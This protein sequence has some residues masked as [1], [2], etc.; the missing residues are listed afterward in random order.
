[1]LC[2]HLHAQLCAVLYLR[3]QGPGAG[4]SV[5]TVACCHQ[6]FITRVCIWQV[7]ASIQLSGVSN[8]EQLIPDYTLSL[9][10]RERQHQ[11]FNYLL[12][13][14]TVLVRLPGLALCLLT[15]AALTIVVWDIELHLTVR[16]V[17]VTLSNKL[18]PTLTSCYT[19]HQAEERLYWEGSY[20]LPTQGVVQLLWLLI[21]WP[22]VAT[23]CNKLPPQ[24]QLESFYLQYSEEL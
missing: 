22:R 18:L 21:W 5:E 11:Y 23:V 12:D 2:Q 24:V 9:I 13:I 15:G 19:K 10:V 1:M 8:Q 14:I 16:V 4:S 17:G 7:T 3:V 20:C 6:L